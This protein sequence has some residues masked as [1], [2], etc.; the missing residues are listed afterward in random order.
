MNALSLNDMIVIL[1][2]NDQS[3][4]CF[5]KRCREIYED[6]I[7]IRLT[8]GV[9]W[10]QRGN[11]S[12]QYEQFNLK[13]KSADLIPQFWKMKD[14]TLYRPLVENYPLVEFIFKIKENYF[15]V[16][17]SREVGGKR[18]IKPA[19]VKKFLDQLKANNNFQSNFTYYYCPSPP[20]ADS[21]SIVFSDSMKD[22]MIEDEV[23]GE[24]VKREMTIEELDEVKKISL[25]I[26]KI[27]GNYGSSLEL[28]VASIFTFISL[29]TITI[30]RYLLTL[31]QLS[32]LVS[33]LS[34]LTLA[35][36][37]T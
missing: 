4:G 37:Q 6:F 14:E 26:I 36:R 19:T 23:N 24:K 15:G 35:K 22:K 29:K 30:Y 18:S 25:K 5:S 12:T 10:Q 33:Q 32:N 3:P 13:L 1:M 28:E 21:A 2:K 9:K 7:A 20:Y 11:E 17:V 16:Q 34:L 8:K 27:P 31:R